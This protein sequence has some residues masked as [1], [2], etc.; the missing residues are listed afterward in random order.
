MNEITLYKYI[1]RVDYLKVIFIKL[2]LSTFVTF[3]SNQT[4]AL[5][6]ILFSF[7]CFILY[8]VFITSA[9]DYFTIIF[10]PSIAPCFRHAHVL[11][12]RRCEYSF[13][14]TIKSNCYLSLIIPF[15]L[16]LLYCYIRYFHENQNEGAAH[17]KK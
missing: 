17:L 11:L 2:A 4:L 9:C 6:P 7:S 12:Y 13:N 3:F 15:H 5:L 16:R 10:L 14:G 8:V 1:K